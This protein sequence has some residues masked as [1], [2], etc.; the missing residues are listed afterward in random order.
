MEVRRRG[1]DA[2]MRKITSTGTVTVPVPLRKAL[3]TGTLLGI[4]HQSGLLRSLF[5]TP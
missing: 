3:K 5:E 2:I 4:I 1:S